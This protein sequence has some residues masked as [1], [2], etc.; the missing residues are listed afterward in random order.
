MTAKTTELR[1]VTLPVEGMTCA[2]CVSHVEGALKD[3]VGVVS[4]NVNLASEEAT[5]EFDG[6]RASLNDLIGAVGDSGY[7]TGLATITLNVGG[8][9]CAACVVHVE[10]AL[11]DVEGVLSANVNLASEQAKVEYLPGLATLPDMRYAVSDAG[12]SV[13]GVA[14]DEASHDAERLAR[15]REIAGLRRRTLVASA[16]GLLIFLGS[17]RELFPWMPSFLQNWYTLWALAT[18]V[19]LWAG[20]QFYLG[21]WGGLKHRTA[22]MNT[23]IA[24]GTSVAYAFSAAATLFPDALS[25]EQADAKVYF[26]TAA[27]IIALI[28]FGRYLEARAK[29]RTSEAIRKLMGLQPRNAIILRDGAAVSV[30]V[31][32]VVPGDVVVVR[33][34]ERLPVDGVVVQGASSVDE[35][36]LTGESVPVEKTVDSHVYGATLNGTGSFHLRATRVGAATALAGIIRMVQD[37]QGSKAPI[38]RL[39]DVVS[40]WFVQVVIGIALATF[41][42]W[43]LAGPSPAYIYAL[44]N[45]VAVLVIACPCAL[46]LATPTAIMAG[47]G[48]GAERGIL[49]RS[50]ESLE[51][52]HRVDN[53]R[54]GQDGN[55]HTG[56]AQ[57]HGSCGLRRDRGATADACGVRGARLRA[58]AARRDPVS[59][60]RARRRSRGCQ[61]L[62]GHTRPRHPRLRWAE[63]VSLWATWHSCVSWTA[64]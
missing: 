18:P 40:G 57:G 33:P 16:L 11:R 20:W 63:S 59:S 60:R 34:G 44:L 62:P 46:G 48:K 3:V 24:V 38:Q 32:D 53:R 43:L 37:A 23:L 30:P 54:A 22:N 41:L 5:V 28:L 7:R 31:D 51:T 29:G 9:T 52:A 6:G 45:M 56:P 47:T 35:S 39:A 1:R 10:H 42:V 26:D 8:M 15:T 12:Y 14:G 64:T 50:A 4:A 21:A 27:I 55:T 2:A 36:M 25:V 58:P 13:E 61:R 17:F 49:I 19:Q